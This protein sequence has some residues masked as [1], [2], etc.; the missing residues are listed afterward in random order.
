MSEWGYRSNDRLHMF[1]VEK[2]VEYALYCDRCALRMWAQMRGAKSDRQFKLW[3]QVG[4]WYR[5]E[6][7]ACV[8]QL[9]YIYQR[10]E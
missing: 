8:N 4:L 5:A 7:W 9:A 3:K 2:L 6:Y 1:T 10:G